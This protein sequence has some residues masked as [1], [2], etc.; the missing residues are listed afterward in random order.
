MTLR[1]ADAITLESGRIPAL[2]RRGQVEAL[3][4]PALADAVLADA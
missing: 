1:D 2:R 4:M 3:A